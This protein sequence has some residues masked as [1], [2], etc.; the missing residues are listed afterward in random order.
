MKP[1]LDRQDVEL[2]IVRLCRGCGEEWP[3]DGEFWYFKGDT[4]KVLGH[5]KAC[6]H[7]RERFA[8]PQTKGFRLI[9]TRAYR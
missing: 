9:G 5:C 6:W 2:G 7:E 3:R 8:K 4:T 1:F